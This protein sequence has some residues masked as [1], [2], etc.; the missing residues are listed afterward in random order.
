MRATSPS[1][2]DTLSADVPE[3]SWKSIC[4]PAKNR[5]HAVGKSYV[6]GVRLASRLH[7]I[8]SGIKAETASS[9]LDSHL[10]RPRRGPWPRLGA[11]LHS[12][13]EERFDR[14]CQGPQQGGRCPSK[15]SRSWWHP[16]SNRITDEVTLHKSANERDPHV[17]RRVCTVWTVILK[18][19]LK[20]ILDG[21]DWCTEN[22]MLNMF[23]AEHPTDLRPPRPR[24]GPVS[25]THLT[26]PTI[27]LV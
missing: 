8:Y 16:L 21:D 22:N 19:A 18:G 12:S 1:T 20:N 3:L 13:A 7:I 17:D 27:L 15:V 24:T 6:G 10:R 5:K 25:Y 9:G 26:L 11:L 14:R 4:R 2:A 23:T